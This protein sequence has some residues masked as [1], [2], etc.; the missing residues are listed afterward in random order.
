MIDASNLCT[1]I[2]KEGKRQKVTKKEV[3]QNIHSGTKYERRYLRDQ[4]K[5]KMKLLRR[6]S[7]AIF[8]FKV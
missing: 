4:N 6:L 8:T 3:D 5:A 1:V 7:P 2:Q